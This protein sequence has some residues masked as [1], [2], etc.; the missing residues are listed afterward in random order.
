[1]RICRRCLVSGLVQGV[2]YRASTAQRAKA[3]GITGHARNLADG[4]VE[5]LA[6][7]DEAA[8]AELCDWLRQGPPAARVAAV[9]IVDIPLDEIPDDFHTR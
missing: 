5:V 7:G 1:M 9:E 8:V 2:F 4:R 3:L 6:Y